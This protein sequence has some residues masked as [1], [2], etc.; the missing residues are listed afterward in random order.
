MCNEQDD[1]EVERLKEFIREYCLFSVA[2]KSHRLSTEKIKQLE[3]DLCINVGSMKSEEENSN[4]KQV[5][6]EEDFAILGEKEVE[7][8]TRESI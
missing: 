3:I 5:E 8:R 7:V 4:I 1:L 2:I 6:K